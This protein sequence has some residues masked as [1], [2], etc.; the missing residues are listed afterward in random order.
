[1]TI[2]IPFYGNPQIFNCIS[3][4]SLSKK[5]NFDGFAPAPSSDMK[6]SF[7]WFFVSVHM[8]RGEDVFGIE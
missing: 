7:Y 5:S 2:I 6:E 4:N 1:M 3:I 8:V